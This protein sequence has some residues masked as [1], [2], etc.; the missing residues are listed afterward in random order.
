MLKIPLTRFMKLYTSS[1]IQQQ[2]LTKKLFAYVLFLFALLESTGH[3]LAQTLPTVLWDKTYGGTTRDEAINIKQTSDGS[4]IIGGNSWSDKNS[5]K[6]ESGKGILD[7]WIIKTDQNGIKIWDKTFGSANNELLADIIETTDGG[8][9]IGGTSAGSGPTNEDKSESSRGASDFWI[10]KLDT[11]GNK[12]WDKTYGG[13][14][15]DKLNSFQETADSGYI[16]GGISNSPAGFDKSQS[17]KGLTDF[18]I[19][20]IDSKGN[21]RWDSTFGG[22]QNDEL[23]V[24]KQTPDGGYLAV[25]TS[26]SEVS[27]DKSSPT[28]G[29]VGE[30]DYWLVKLDA[31]GNKLWDKTY[32]GDA[33]EGIE[34]LL[35]L[36][37]GNFII[38]GHSNSPVSGEKT[39][40]PYQYHFPHYWLLKLDQNGNKIWDKS[41]EDFS[42]FSYRLISANDHGFLLGSTFNPIISKAQ[43]KGEYDL[44]IFRLD[45]F[46]NKV[47]D[48]IIGSK[49]SDNCEGMIQTTDGTF[50]LLGNSLTGVSADKTHA[51]YG[52]SDYWVVKLSAEPK[53]SNLGP[54]RPNFENDC[55]GTYINFTS[56]FT[57]NADSVSWN[58][59]D[60]PSGASNSSNENSPYHNFTGPGPYNITLTVYEK[61]IESIYT[62]L[63]IINEIPVVDLGKE[64]TFCAGSTLQLT[65]LAASQPGQTYSW[66]TGDTTATLN[67]TQPG[68][69]TLKVGNGSCFTS[70]S[71]TVKADFCSENFRIP[72][73]IT[74]NSDDK[75]DKFVIQGILPK[76]GNLKI[77][78][79]WGGLIY[80]NDAYD[81]NWPEEKITPGTYY[82]FLNLPEYGKT[83]KGWIEVSY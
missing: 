66:S 51:G 17:S 68:T 45:S 54:I 18:W 57:S 40:T 83:T 76:Q 70:A 25:G 27:G 4:Y 15:L 41:L 6:S 55:A 75:N 62:S 7:Y 20:K 42:V 48:K 16:L 21:K 1:F 13:N 69:Y 36:P 5:V 77:Y 8:Y 44:R 38:G 61:G 43:G 26:N 47:W 2:K 74:P 59:D 71:V 28:R 81:N 50:V 35:L 3:V 79:R 24:I 10:I 72:N 67:V 63:L 73:I 39:N 14:H 29:K 19:I 32:G 52:E 53:I 65:N 22:T 49:K 37:D 30:E 12:I 23:K 9:L 11:N 56:P 64:Q 80:Q 34:N 60:P 33:N 82:Y 31:N 46:G 58:F 78:N